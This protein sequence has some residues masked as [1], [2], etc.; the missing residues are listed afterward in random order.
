MTSSNAQVRDKPAL[1]LGAMPWYSAQILICITKLLDKTNTDWGYIY[2][3]AE[4][5]P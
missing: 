4:I 3:P 5:Y 1:V 2:R